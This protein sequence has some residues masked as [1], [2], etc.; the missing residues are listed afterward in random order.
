[1]RRILFLCTDSY[2]IS[3]HLQYQ[4]DIQTVYSY[5]EPRVGSKYEDIVW[6]GI[7]PYLKEYGLIGE[8]VT[9]NDLFEACAICDEHFG[10]LK[11]FNLNDWTYILDRYNGNLPIRIYALPAGTIVK[12]GTPCMAIENTDP[13]VPWLTNY[14]ESMLMHAW[15]MTT[16][17]TISYKSYKVIK[18]YCDKT[19]EDVNPF[20]FNDFGL[21]GASSLESAMLNGIG[22]LAV[23]K[24][25]DNL[26]AIK[27]IN[28]NYADHIMAGYS[29]YAAEHSTVTSYGKENELEAYKTIIGNAPENMTVAVVID[30]YEWRYALDNY[31]CKDLV[32]LIKNRTGKVV[33][34]PDSGNPVQ[35]SLDIVQKLWETYGGSHTSKGYKLLN[36]KIGI[37]YG[38]HIDP[39]MIGAILDKF[40][41]HGFAVNNIIFGCGGALL[42]KM[43]RD[44]CNCAIKLSEITKDNEVIPICKTT[45]GKESKSG[46]FDL[47]VI[48]E[49]G[50]LLVNESFTDIRQRVGVLTN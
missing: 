18:D 29:V 14:V 31:F 2:K 49:N 44:T 5:F 23:F 10:T 46:R 43:N 8:C 6:M 30:S 28:E 9:Y 12:P 40:T 13:E 47:P 32:E 48:F 45:P 1:M 25:T 16:T 19:G 41:N 11:Y 27:F 20:A 21:R 26:P 50:K 33:V 34:R 4:K 35:V 24:G 7:I 22:H 3:H 36:P 42:Q 37:I 17:A 39:N 38:D 15:A